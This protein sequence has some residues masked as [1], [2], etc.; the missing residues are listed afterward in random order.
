MQFV[1]NVPCFSTQVHL[2]VL[3]EVNV[4]TRNSA[5]VVDLMHLDQD[6]RQVCWEETEWISV[7]ACRFPQQKKNYFCLKVPSSSG[8]FPSLSFLW[9]C[10]ALHYIS[11]QIKSKQ[12][13]YFTS[14][15]PFV[16]VQHR[17]WKRSYMPNMGS[18]SLW[19][20]WW[21]LF[22]FFWEIHICTCETHW[23]RWAEFFYTG[24]GLCFYIPFY[25]CRTCWCTNVRRL[26]VT[27]DGS[28]GGSRM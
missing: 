23:I 12:Q 4:S 18:I 9:C 2:C 6:V 25:C 22:L 7:I 20:F 26:K 5:T 24:R 13:Q 16:S 8:I 11:I 27:W 3:M 17:C 28:T 15:S 1:F 14:D 21:T 10:I 19:N